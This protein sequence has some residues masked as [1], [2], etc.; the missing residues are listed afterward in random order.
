MSPK[1]RGR[2]RPHPARRLPAGVP[3]QGGGLALPALAEVYAAYVR[4]A[5][6]LPG[7]PGALQAELWVSAQLGAL[8]SAAPHAEGFRVALADLAGRLD[9][10]GSP[11]ARLFLR[12]LAAIGPRPLRPLAGRLAGEGTEPGWAGELGQ[13]TAGPAWLIQEGPLD[14]DRLIC[15]YRY[16]GGTGQHALAVR[17][18]AELPTEIVVVGDVPGMFADVR[19]AV[20][21][22]L[23][24]IMPWDPTAA[25][26][27]LRA[28]L[29]APG[30]LPADCYPA[31]TLARHRVEP[32]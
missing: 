8:E 12:V 1:S 14:G 7:L 2:T 11:G 16:P 15:E 5:D 20:Q 13:V 4:A 28:S 22:E 18:S 26:A 31:L 9:A 30:G 3:S 24:V 17:L 6:E 19:R 23:C 25:A 27:R 10:A 29:D 21:A 32:R